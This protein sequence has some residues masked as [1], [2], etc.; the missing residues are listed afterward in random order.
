MKLDRL[1]K[2]RKR[3]QVELDAKPVFGIVSRLFEVQPDFL[4]RLA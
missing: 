4:T 1:V 3:G 2:C